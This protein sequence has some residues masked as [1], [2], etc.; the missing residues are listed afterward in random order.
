MPRAKWSE[1]QIIGILKQVEAGRTVVDV[2]REH[3]VGESTFYKWNTAQ[4]AP[5]MAVWKSRKP[6]VSKL[7][8]RRMLVSS[9]Y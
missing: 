1:E 8:K 4:G 2:C 5:G 3:G 9:A 7:L 6:S